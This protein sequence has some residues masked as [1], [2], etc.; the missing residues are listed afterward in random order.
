MAQSMVQGSVRSMVPRPEAPSAKKR[1]P[2]PS[3]CSGRSDAG[4]AAAKR[5]VASAALGRQSVNFASTL[6]EEVAAGAGGTI[7]V[8]FSVHY[9][10]G[11]G[12]V[13]KLVG[14]LPVTGE[15][16]V[17]AAPEMH[18]DEGHF[19]RAAIEVPRGA[20]L[21][22]KLVHVSPGSGAARWE[23][24]GNHHF[25]V[26]PL[27]AAA[28]APVCGLAVQTAWNNWHPDF[29]DPVTEPIAAA[30]LTV[31]A[32]VAAP[33][34]APSAFTVADFFSSRSSSPAA[35]A[36]LATASAEEAAPAPSSAL[37]APPQLLEDE[38]LASAP[39][40]DEEELSPEEPT[41]AAKLEVTKSKRPFIRM[42]RSATLAAMGMAAAGVAV[43]ALG[44]AAL[45]D[46]AVSGALLAGAAAFMPGSASSKALKAKGAAGPAIAALAAGMDLVDS[47]NSM[48]RAASATEEVEAAA[49][50]EEELS[51]QPEGEAEETQ[52]ES[53]VIA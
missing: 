10:A 31:A 29:I 41:A 49:D 16:D 52:Q 11:F 22:Y 53:D 2:R 37:A 20:E 40:E 3:R 44:D 42:G 7:P 23:E 28:E 50:S 19:W 14:S 39:Q 6:D 43:T 26:A 8:N 46:V 17:T 9:V 47:L 5:D 45:L 32:P 18:W 15:W 51:E 21:E 12:D 34:A 48:T 27:E 4:R 30:P 38:V 1:V 33:L 13:L 35:E 25:A 24:E 36:P